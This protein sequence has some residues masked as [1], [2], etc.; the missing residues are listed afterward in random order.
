MAV[1]TPAA[2]LRHAR[3]RVRLPNSKPPA[4]AGL[5]RS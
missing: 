4:L 2:D 3:V 1:A 5:E